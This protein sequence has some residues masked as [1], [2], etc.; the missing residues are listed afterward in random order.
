[1]KNGAKVLGIIYNPG[2]INN[3]T[4]IITTAINIK[5]MYLL[6]RMWCIGFKSGLKPKLTMSFLN[7]LIT[8]KDMA[9]MAIPN[10]ATAG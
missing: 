9:Y 2:V 6:G 10:I 8:H 3:D 5:R 7:E 1:M 4:A